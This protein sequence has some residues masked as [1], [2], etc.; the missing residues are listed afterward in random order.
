MAAADYSDLHAAIKA[1]VTGKGFTYVPA[2]RWFNLEYGAFPEALKNNSFTIRFESQGESIYST[3]WA[4]LLVTVEF[5]LES[6]KDKYLDKIKTCIEAVSDVGTVTDDDIRITDRTA[7]EGFESNYLDRS[8][9][10]TFNNI[11]I[12]IKAKE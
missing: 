8:V 11:P 4:Q 1:K 10:I 2:D 12:E 6:M 3:D 5:I 7:I 9:I